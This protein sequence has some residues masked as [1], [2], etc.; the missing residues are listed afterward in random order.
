VQASNTN[1]PATLLLKVFSV[2]VAGSVRDEQI[3]V[4][5]MRAIGSS[6]KQRPESKEGRYNA[7]KDT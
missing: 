6:T 7:F 4:K 2:G 1:S 3:F 5:W